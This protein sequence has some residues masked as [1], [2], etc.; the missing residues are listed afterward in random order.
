MCVIQR[1]INISIKKKK[2]NSSMYNNKIYRVNVE[3]LLN[4][5]HLELYKLL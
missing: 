4:C 3:F 1:S 5:A 2:K